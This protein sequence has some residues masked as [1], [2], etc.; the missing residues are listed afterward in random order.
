M[1]GCG[2]ILEECEKQGITAEPVLKGF[3]EYKTAQKPVTEEEEFDWTKVSEMVNSGIMY[4]IFG[5]YRAP[6]EEYEIPDQLV[7]QAV[8]KTDTAILVIGR[9]SG[10]EECDRH[11]TENYYLT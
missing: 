11:L 2:T 4:E 3:Y 10:G 6:L 1:A 7:S 8:E 5:R 9:N